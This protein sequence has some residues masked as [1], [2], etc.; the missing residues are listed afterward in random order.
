MSK[1]AS[2][3][4]ARDEHQMQ[5]NQSD[6][7]IPKF[8]SEHSYNKAAIVTTDITGSSTS[9]SD[10]TSRTSFNSVLPTGAFDTADVVNVEVTR[11]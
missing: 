7:E 11:G 6:L 4:H 1:I 3:I 8:Y 9:S 5:I 10:T 2:L